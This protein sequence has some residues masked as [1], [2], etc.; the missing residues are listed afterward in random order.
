MEVHQETSVLL[1]PRS[2]PAAAPKC[3]CI[4]CDHNMNA[5]DTVD[6]S[7]H[8]VEIGCK[9]KP[10]RGK[11]S[12]VPIKPTDKTKSGCRHRAKLAKR[13]IDAFK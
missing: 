1:A 9:A 10:V 6:Y 8:D 13:H 3:P 4:G 7:D 11:W 5:G 12:F 2:T